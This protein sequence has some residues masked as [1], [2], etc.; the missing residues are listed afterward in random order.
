MTRPPGPHARSRATALAGVTAL[1]A[2]E[3]LV[4]RLL[5]SRHGVP[6]ISSTISH[7][8]QLGA[9]GAAIFNLAMLFVGLAVV[10]LLAA[11]LDARLPASRAVRL[12]LPAASL[13]LCLAARAPIDPASAAQTWLHRVLAA[14]GLLAL[15]S[16]AFALSRCGPARSRPVAA[17][18]SA[19]VALTAGVLLVSI[20]PLYL[21]HVLVGPIEWLAVGLLVGWLQALLLLL[22]LMPPGNRADTRVST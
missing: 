9:D 5:V 1:V 19:G 6:P 7:L 4:I 14:S 11:W 15:A 2:A 10:L 20:L 18:M 13:G 17:P 3:V 22:L 8:G 16:A 21:L 12:L